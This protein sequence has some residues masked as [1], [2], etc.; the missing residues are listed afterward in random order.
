VVSILI[1]L[2]S[3]TLFGVLSSYIYGGGSKATLSAQIVQ[4]ESALTEISRLSESL[5]KL[6]SD[7]ETTAKEKERIESEYKKATELKT[8][9]Q[10]QLAA[11]RAAVAHRSISEII[12]D[13]LISFCLGV[14][15]SLVA[16]V[17]W[18]LAVERRKRRAQSS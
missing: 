17:L 4:V 7:L 14:T 9:T 16:T 18:F 8:L 3:S 2:L 1:G 6:K 12:T 15:S 10:S 11:V 5:G 13:N